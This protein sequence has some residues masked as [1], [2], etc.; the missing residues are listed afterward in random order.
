MLDK[1]GKIITIIVGLI[2]IPLAAMQVINIYKASTAE[3][4]A[5]AQ[6][7]KMFIDPAV[8]EGIEEL[9][10]INELDELH[11]LIELDELITL[12]KLNVEDGKENYNNFKYKVIE[13]RREIRGAVE[14]V[15]Y[16]ARVKASDIQRKA[17]DSQGVWVITVVNEGSK[18]AESI[19]LKIPSC[20]SVSILREGGEPSYKES[21]EIIELG[22]LQPQESVSVKA[23]VGYYS[24]VDARLTYKNGIG[25]VIISETASPF[26]V[27]MDR[28]WGLVAW[29]LL[30][31]AVIINLLVPTSKK[32]SAST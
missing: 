17:R 8:L 23:W 20:T 9:G 25:K 15:K 10:D 29:L 26:W 1:Y 11:E 5:K 13:I 14:E 32:Q 22:E 27:W 24:H 19:K 31:G 2:T 12:S 7:H 3:L 21:S 4:V 6:Y 28:K 30:M 16:A 18:A